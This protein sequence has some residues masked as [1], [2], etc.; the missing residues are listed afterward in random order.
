[1]KTQKT[2]LIAVA[3][4]LF[5][6]IN[7]FSQDKKR[8]RPSPE[9]MF[10]KLDT[11]KD[12]KIV[13]DEIK[14]ERLANRFDKMDADGDGGITLEEL[15]SSFEKGKKGKENKLK[16]GK[17]SSE[18]MFAKLDVN[19]DGVLVKEEIKNEK[20][21]KRFDKI[22]ADA[23]GEV[24]VEEF[25]AFSEKAKQSKDRILN[26]EKPLKDDGFDMEDED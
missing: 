3:I 15:K 14:N 21:A 23:N 25:K 16:G 5:V 24:T 2:T 1:M 13:K 22:D 19:K 10:E 8:E 17:V 7:A 9:Q 12:G 6:G 20:L 4:C 26:K 18:K 11:N